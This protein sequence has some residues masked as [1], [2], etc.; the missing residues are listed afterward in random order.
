MFMKCIALLILS[1]VYH[2]SLLSVQRVTAQD[3]PVRIADRLYKVSESRGGNVVFLVTDDGVIVVDAGTYPAQGRR[4]GEQV[5]TV[6]DKP[7]KYI[8]LTHYHWDHT[9][10]LVS[11]PGSPVIIGHDHISAHLKRN[12]SRIKNS[13]EKDL[14][15]QIDE[16][17][18]NIDRYKK[19][20]DT[21]LVGAEKK[22][23]DLQNYLDE[24]NTARVI[25]PS[26][27]FNESM[28]IYAGHDTVRLIYPGPAHTRCN[29]LVHFVNQRT[30]HM[31]DMLFHGRVPYIIWPDGSNT[32]NWIDQLQKV[33][34]WDIDLVIPGHGE[35]TDKS[36]L[37][38][39]INYLTSLRQAVRNAIQK[40]RT[41]E[42]M[43]NEITLPEFKHLEWPQL[44]KQNIESVYNEMTGS[45]KTTN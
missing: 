44:L 35:I 30:V 17:K 45:N 5:A 26:V 12:E 36:G 11:F 27:T 20:H 32:E 6:T 28:T 3:G 42:Q 10:G 21:N 8:L 25:Y 22:L 16:L 23:K 31:G 4:I 15:A 37:Q 14:P 18:K 2:L 13:I 41:L 43:Q 1:A 39:K 19:N 29:I 9:A 38:K 40:G 24:M 7:I 34:A 33:M